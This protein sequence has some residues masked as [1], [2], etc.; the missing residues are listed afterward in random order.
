MA[1]NPNR[2]C[3]V[4]VLFIVVFLPTGATTASDSISI[5]SETEDWH[6]ILEEMAENELI[7]EDWE[8]RLT[9]LANNP[10]QL[11]NASREALENIPILNEEQVENLSY[12]L[13]RYGPMVSLSELLLVEGM[14][15][16]TMRWLKPF[17]C[18][19]T[20]EESPVEYPPLKK[21]LLYGKQELRWSMGSSIQQKQGF[22]GEADSTSRY[23]GDPIHA[24][25]RYGFD[26][27]DRLQWGVV[28]EKDPGET[29][30][31]AQKGGVDYVSAHLLIKDTKRRNTLIL[32]DYKVRY[33]QGLVCGSSFSLGKNTSGTVPELTGSL[34]SRHFSS[35]ETNYFRGVAFRLTLKPYIKEKGCLFG[36]ELSTFLSSKKLDSTVGNGSFTSISNTGL[37][38]TL[39]EVEN[40]KQLN[41]TVIGSHLQLRWTNLTIGIS[42]LGWLFDA[43]AQESTESWKVFNITGKKGGNASADFRT[44]WKGLLVFGEFALDQNGHTAMLAGLTFK[45]HPRMNVSILARKYE[46]QYQGLFSNAFSEGSTSKNEEGLYTATDFQL[47]K[48][49]RLSGYVDVFRFP[50][51]GYAVS[52]PSWGQDA[53]AELNMTVGRNGVVKLLIKSK[54]KEKCSSSENLPTNPIQSDLKN[55]MRLQVAQKHGLWTMKS[56]LYANTYR[57]TKNRSKGYAV[58]QD[59]GFEPTGKKYSMVFHTVLFNTQGWENKIYLWEKDLPGAFSMP[60]LY[61]EGFRSALFARYNLRNLCLQVKAS[62]SV[63]PRLDFI[64]IGPEQIKGNR[65]TEVRFQL[66]WKF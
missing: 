47:A 16:R 45:P 33:G 63:Q 18:L 7:T 58:A 40:Q 61:G 56:I 39:K 59:F 46:P 12:Y 28:L 43:S 14:D 62:D 30:W 21:A 37:H 64:G 31:N 36:M 1:C 5:N 35:S 41:Q 38:R 50:W 2:I 54:S 19:G 11:N 52:T 53:A 10:V 13:Y 22:S 26:Y 6:I 34:L 23:V 29:W 55:Q 8:E 24:I 51:L 44:I 49:I 32:G 60:M 65:R 48:R 15:A 3:T 4:V 17:V 20:S 42:S 57:F 66:S 9:E 27:K 25:L